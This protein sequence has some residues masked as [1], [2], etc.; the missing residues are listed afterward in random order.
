M[1]NRSLDGDTL[2]IQ[3]GEQPSEVAQLLYS[4]SKQKA[5][6]KCPYHS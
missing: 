3:N 6:E 2:Q 4:S 5:E 1:R